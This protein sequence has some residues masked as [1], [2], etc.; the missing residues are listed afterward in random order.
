[1]IYLFIVSLL[2]APSFGL[3]KNYLGG[4]DSNFVAAVRIVLSLALFVPF[5]RVG[6]IAPRR[7]LLLAGIGAVQFGFMYVLYLRSF[8]WLKSSEV[9]LFTI[10]TPLLVTLTNDVL[11]RRI[12][13]LFIA[14]AGLAVVGTGIIQWTELERGGL[15]A[16]FLMMQLSN[17]CFAVGQV[18]YRRVA[19]GAGRPDHQLMGILY[20]GATVVALAFAA[21]S[22]DFSAIRNISPVQWVVLGYLGVIASGVGFFLF[23]A[24]ARRVD[25]GALAIFNNVKVPLAILASVLFFGERVDAL[26]L[27]IGGAV[28]ALA[29]AINEWA[30]RCR[31]RNAELLRLGKEST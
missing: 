11:E 8:T 14:T 5:I 10:F 1:M 12:S 23:N 7:L 18:L 26:R 16:G 29:L 6:G 31:A 27:I 21:S 22:V 20:L 9:A 24:G 17:A 4:V 2:W 3:V 19:P 15:L 13:W 28:I 30:V 25:V